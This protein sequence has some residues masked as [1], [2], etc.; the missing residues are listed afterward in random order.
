[1]ESREWMKEGAFFSFLFLEENLST[2]KEGDGGLQSQTVGSCLSS[3]NMPCSLH[4]TNRGLFKLRHKAEN[5]PLLFF[6]FSCS[7]QNIL[8]TA[9]RRH[10]LGCCCCCCTWLAVIN[11][12]HGLVVQ[13][14]LIS[15]RPTKDNQHEREGKKARS[16]KLPPLPHPTSFDHHHHLLVLACGSS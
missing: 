7:L 12:S 1:M 13:R 10:R 9:A 2:H 6:F 11:D 16:D 5:S 8:L 4:I 14:W 15:C 3:T